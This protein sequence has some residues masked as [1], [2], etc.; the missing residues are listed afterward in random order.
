MAPW[1][2]ATGLVLVLFLVAHLLGV[3]LALPA[4]AAF[5]RYAAHLHGRLWLPPLELA[6]ASAAVVHAATALQRQRAHRLA[7]GVPP[8][9]LR[10][11]RAAAEG[12]QGHAAAL[13]GRLLPWSGALILAFLG[14]HLVQLRWSR[15]ATGEELATLLAVLQRPGWLAL[16]AAAGLAVG[17]HLLHANEGAHRSLGLLDAANAGPIRRVGRAAALLLGAGFA[18]L[19]LL[20]W[21]RGP[22]AA[23]LPPGPP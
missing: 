14:V 13:A 20:L 23:P 12:I 5:E 9:L 16:Y 10:S 11:R 7:R 15:P 19:P 18:L 6:L 1:T 2:A 3:G 22:V 21:L 4:P 17:L 8:A